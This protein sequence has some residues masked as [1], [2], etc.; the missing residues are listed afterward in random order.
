MNNAINSSNEE[1]HSQPKKSF[2]TQLSIVAISLILTACSSPEERIQKLESEIGAL[3]HTLL[4]QQKNYRELSTQ[5]NIQIDIRD[6]WADS[7]INW[8]IND[9]TERANGYTK[10]IQKTKEKIS[11]KQK[12]LNKLREEYNINT[13]YIPIQQKLDPSKFDY[14]PEEYN[15]SENRHN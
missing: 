15:R 7:S 14:L 13:N 5:Q 10:E 6:E 11:K 12:K 8:E 4:T 1:A 9:A 3:K 2:L